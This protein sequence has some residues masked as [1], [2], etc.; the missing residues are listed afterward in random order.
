MTEITPQPIIPRR[1]GPFD[2]PLIPRL[3]WSPVRPNGVLKCRDHGQEYGTVDINA[4]AEPSWSNRTKLDARKISGIL[5]Y[6]QSVECN[7]RNNPGTSDVH[8]GRLPQLTIGRLI[9]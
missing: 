1:T 2:A 5:F 4:D 9:L 6:F 7:F 8:V 3:H